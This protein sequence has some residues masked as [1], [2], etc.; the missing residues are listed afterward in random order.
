MTKVKA[1]TCSRCGD[2]IFSRARD[3][4]RYC[5]CG[6]IFIDGGFDDIKVGGDLD[7]KIEELEINATKQEL[8]EDWNSHRDKFGLIKR[9]DRK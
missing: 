4:C 7:C 1:V 3:D 9:W 6:A 2:T 8:Y 5:S